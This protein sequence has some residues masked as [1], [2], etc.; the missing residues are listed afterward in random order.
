VHEQHGRGVILE[1]G[2]DG[3]LPHASQLDEP[4]DEGVDVT[5]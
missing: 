4:L 1:E 5:V 2:R 3:R